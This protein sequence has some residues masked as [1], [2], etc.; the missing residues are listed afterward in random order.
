MIKKYNI[1]SGLYIL[2]LTCNFDNPSS[3]GLF[4]DGIENSIYNTK[5][6]D[7]KILNYLFIYQIVRIDSYVHI[8]KISEETNQ[9]HNIDFTLWKL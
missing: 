3:I 6:Y 8:K 1:D 9:Y 2:K 7:S 4:I 5:I